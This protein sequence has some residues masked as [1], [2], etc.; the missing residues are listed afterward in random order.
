MINENEIEIYYLKNSFINEILE[1]TLEDIHSFFKDKR[2]AMN[3]NSILVDKLISLDTTLNEIY[4]NELK[5]IDIDLE[6]LNDLSI[7]YFNDLHR[8]YIE[9]F[10]IIENYYVDIEEGEYMEY[11]DIII[12]MECKAGYISFANYIDN[13]IDIILNNKIDD[14]DFIENSIKQLCTYHYII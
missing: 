4:T 3:I 8:W 11:E 9:K 7:E 12:E 10:S 1:N 5:S 2:K 13:I 6:W 14:V